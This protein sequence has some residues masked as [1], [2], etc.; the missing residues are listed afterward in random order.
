MGCIIT[1]QQGQKIDDINSGIAAMAPCTA[2]PAPDLERRDGTEPL[3]LPFFVHQAAASG[4]CTRST[5]ES[6]VPACHAFAACR[7]KPGG[8]VRRGGRVYQESWRRKE[9]AEE[10]LRGEAFILSQDANS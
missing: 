6:P 5:E 7:P 10:E 4:I 3:L 8:K 2:L 9:E 1:L